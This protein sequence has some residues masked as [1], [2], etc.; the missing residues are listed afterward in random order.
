VRQDIAEIARTAV[1]LLKEA[2][3]KAQPHGVRIPV[4]LVVRGSSSLYQPRALGP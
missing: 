3:S 1:R 4:Q 2:M